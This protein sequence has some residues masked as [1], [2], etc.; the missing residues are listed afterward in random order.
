ML[1]TCT[2]VAPLAAFAVRFT[3]PASV[4]HR[5]PITMSGLAAEL[6]LRSFVD[7]GP[8]PRSTTP[9]S[10]VTIWLTRKSP[11]ESW[12]TCP[13]GQALIAAWI[14]ADASLAPLPY[15]EALM[16]AHTVVRAGIPPGM[17][18]FHVVRRAVGR[19]SPATGAAYA[20]Q[21]TAATVRRRDFIGRL[22]PGRVH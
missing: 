15:V 17:P 13:T 5:W 22:N 9:L 19:T 11:A 21:H 10:I 14:P 12:T 6:V 3:E 2:D 18:G 1:D 7:E 20:R 16:V 8:A 4:S